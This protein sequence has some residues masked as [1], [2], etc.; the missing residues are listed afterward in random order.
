MAAQG[1]CHP[2]ARQDAQQAVGRGGRAPTLGGNASHPLCCWTL[3][4]LTSPIGDVSRTVLMPLL[5][6]LEKHCF[7]FPD[8]NVL[9]SRGAGGHRGEGAG[10]GALAAVL[11]SLNKAWGEQSE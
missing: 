8:P 6:S 5:V 2:A 9:F 10:W 1:T 3:S 4:P 11:L 7:G